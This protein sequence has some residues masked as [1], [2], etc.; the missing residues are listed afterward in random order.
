MR[1]WLCS[2]I[3]LFLISPSPVAA[4]M[5]YGEVLAEC[6]TLF[7]PLVSMA[8]AQ[9]FVPD[10]PLGDEPDVHGNSDECWVEFKDKDWAPTKLGSATPLLQFSVTHGGDQARKYSAQA[11]MTSQA[12]KRSYADVDAAKFTGVTKAFSYTGFGRHVLTMLL[13]KNSVTVQI[14]DRYP[15]STLEPFAALVL[16]AIAKPE[17]KAWR[18]RK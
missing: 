9:R 18:E 2:A 6:V 1:H 16:E 4:Q 3:F 13:E 14:A 5:T 12:A 8:Q 11:K 17:L 7:S 15:S 10:N